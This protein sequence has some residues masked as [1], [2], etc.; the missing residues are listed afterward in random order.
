MPVIGWYDSEKNKSIDFSKSGF[1]A[2]SEEQWLEKDKKIWFVENNT[3][4]DHVVFPTSASSLNI[5]K[6]NCSYNLKQI[7]KNKITLGFL[8][9]ALGTSYF[10][11]SDVI[12]QQNIITNTQSTS[13]GLISCCDTTGKWHKILHTKQQSQQVIDDFVLFRDKLIS[14]LDGYITK[15]NN[16]SSEIEIKSV[17]WE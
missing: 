16:A 15:I 6:N 5:L 11:A 9:N 1:L 3:L 8:S 13:G 2:V 4:V 14:K 10:Y 17:V 7:C 12:D